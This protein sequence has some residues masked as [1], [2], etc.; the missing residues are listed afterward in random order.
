MNS[1]L[2][3][4][5]NQSSFSR[6]LQQSNAALLKG[7]CLGLLFLTLPLITYGQY[8]VEWKA[9]G[10]PMPTALTNNAVTGSGNHAYSFGGIDSS[11]SWSG[12]SREAFRF[13]PSAGTWLTLPPVPD[14]LGKIAMAASAVKDKIYVIGG[15]HVLESGAEISSNKVHV[16][17][18]LSNTWMDDGA[19]M[20]VPVDDHVQVVYR[21]SL[22]YVVTG[23]SNTGNVPHVQIYNPAL[24]SWQFGTPVPA[25]NQFMAF[26]A[27][28]AMIHGT[29]TIVYSGGARM[30]LNFPIAPYVRIGQIDSEDATMITWTFYEHP[31]AG[32]YRAAA[33]QGSEYGGNM[34]HRIIGGS[35]KTYNFDGLAYDGSGPVAPQTLNFI[36]CKSI[37]LCDT[38][39]S[40][41]ELP[42]DLAVMDLRG[43]AVIGYLGIS[44]I[45]YYL[46]GG[47]DSTLKPTGRAYHC[48]N[49]YEGL[50]QLHLDGMS[51]LPNLTHGPVQVRVDEPSLAGFWQYQVFDLNG[52][53]VQSGELYPP[54]QIELGAH[55][56]GLYLL[57]LQQGDRRMGSKVAVL[58]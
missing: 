15:Y 32:R 1:L 48:W 27:S 8:F 41:H 7:F 12:I 21:D 37:L 44:P 40:I 47:M 58:K 34:F 10:E 28:G 13:N 43:M 53:L 36:D 9:F 24:D 46:L 30:G 16:F 31:L 4:V 38:F 55:P 3:S 49:L 29:G 25:N 42:T 35:A 17:D 22:I 5:L 23:W 45:D 54:A 50:E 51:V 33:D 14:T 56:N 18:V 20:P 2:P 6:M 57:S 39:F 52:R 11:L 26:G 19:N